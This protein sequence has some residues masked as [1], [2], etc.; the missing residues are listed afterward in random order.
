ML[1]SKRDDESEMLQK[2]FNSEN[3]KKIAYIDK[4]AARLGRSFLVGFMKQ[5]NM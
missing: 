5:L 3:L 4:T 1:S 2:I